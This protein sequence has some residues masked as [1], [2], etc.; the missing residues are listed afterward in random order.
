MGILWAHTSAI[1][2]IGLNT[3]SQE[4]AHTDTGPDGYHPRPHS[5]RK[6]TRSCPTTTDTN[7]RADGVGADMGGAHQGQCSRVLFPVIVILK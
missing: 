5:H 6:P 1:G 2:C 3:H 7:G 4:N